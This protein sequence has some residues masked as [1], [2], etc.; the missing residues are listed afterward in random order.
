MRQISSW[1]IFAQQKMRERLEI[2][3][4]RHWTIFFPKTAKLEMC[5]L[6][7]GFSNCTYVNHEFLSRA[8]A[9]KEILLSN[10]AEHIREDR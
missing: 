4:A 6:A 9:T 1:C 7:G 3:A 5:I 2:D 10:A 8:K